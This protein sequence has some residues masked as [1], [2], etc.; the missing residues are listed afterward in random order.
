MAREDDY[1]AML[2]AL[3]TRMPRED[4][5][6]ALGVDDGTLDEIASGYVPEK[7]VALQ[8]RALAEGAKW[9]LA[10]TS[11]KVIIA[12]V[13]ADTIFFAILAAIFLLR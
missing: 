6:D 4:I 3:E 12:F 2:A 5:A 8:L 1:A 7:D 13:I 9:R 11:M 10:S